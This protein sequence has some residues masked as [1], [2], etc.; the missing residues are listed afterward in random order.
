MLNGA[1]TSMVL[2]AYLAGHEIVGDCM[3]DPTMR[4]YMS[5]ALFNE[6]MPTLDLPKDDL[7]AFASAIFER[8]S[9][10]FN[11]H[12]LLSI[13]LNSQS[14]FR[15]RVLP[16]IKDMSSGTGSLAQDSDLLH[17]GVHRVLLR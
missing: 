16:T 9:N 15:A 3:A 4:S 11:R 2:G 6:I 12:L 1:H 5:Q 14:K 13:A 17:G 7:E 10:P 8:F